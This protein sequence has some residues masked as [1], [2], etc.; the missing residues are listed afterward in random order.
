MSSHAPDFRCWLSCEWNDLP[1]DECA[2]EELMTAFITYYGRFLEE[3]NGVDT[4]NLDESVHS[5]QAVMPFYFC[6]VL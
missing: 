4:D 6:V 5:L 2:K 3:R 1:N